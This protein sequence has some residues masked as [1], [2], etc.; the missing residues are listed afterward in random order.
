MQVT[1]G[2]PRRSIAIPEWAFERVNKVI[3]TQYRNV[4]YDDDKVIDNNI[5]FGC[6]SFDQNVI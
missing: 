4:I 1:G 5:L 2:S 3:S 6:V